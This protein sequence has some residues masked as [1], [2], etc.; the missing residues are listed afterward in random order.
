VVC[1]LAKVTQVVKVYDFDEFFLIELD[2]VIIYFLLM[3]LKK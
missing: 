2:L 3:W 1:G